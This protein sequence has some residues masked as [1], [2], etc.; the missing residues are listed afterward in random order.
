M[1]QYLISFNDE[2]VP[3]RTDDQEV[4]RFEGRGMSSVPGVPG[5]SGH[6]RGAGE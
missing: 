4:H 5:V 3:A 6:G 2:W 1:P